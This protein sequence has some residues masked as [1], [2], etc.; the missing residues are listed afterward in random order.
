MSKKFIGALVTLLLSTSGFMAQ[1]EDNNESARFID[2]SQEGWFWYVEPEEPEEPEQLEIEP[3]P[4]PV[5]RPEPTEIAPQKGPALFSSA[6]IRDN[7]PK[8]LD[9]ASVL[10]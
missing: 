8:Y 5:V 10:R 6:W 2:R 1:A 9:Q 7:L 3:L 4:A